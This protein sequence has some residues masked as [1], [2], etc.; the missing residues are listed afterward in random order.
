MGEVKSR[1]SRRR[2][3]QHDE[4]PRNAPRMQVR[5]S[6]FGRIL[7]FVEQFE[8]ETEEALGPWKGSGERRL[9]LHM[10]RSHLA[11]RLVTPSSLV[12]ASGLGYGTGVR[13]VEKMIKQNLIARRPRTRSGKTFSLHP[14]PEMIRLWHEYTRRIKTLL[15]ST[16]GWSERGEGTGDYFFG[17][18]YMCAQVIPPLLVLKERLAIGGRLRLLLHADPTFMAMTTV[19]RQLET[20]FGAEIW[21]RALSIDRLH[22]E[23]LE[24]SARAHSSYDIIACDL[25]W[26]GELAS[27][28]VLLPL[29]DLLYED[30]HDLSD[31]HPEAVSSTSWDEIQYGVPVQTSPELLV[32]RKDLFDEAGLEEPRSVEALLE[33]ACCLHDPI[34]GRA[35]IAWNAARGTPIGHTFLMM[36]ADFGQPVID[37]RKTD[38][39]FCIHELTGNRYRPMFLSDAARSAAEFM[40]EL[41][42]FSP[43]NILNMSWYERAKCYASGGAAMAYCYTLLAS[44][45]ER[46]N[47]SPAYRKT[48]Y[49]PHPHG[50]GC[51]P[52]APLG[53]YALALPSNL[54]EERSAEA[55]RA[56]KVLT[57]PGA[58]KLYLTQ[59]SSTSPRFS[60]GE[61]PD[62][63]SLCPSIPIVDA[64]ARDGVLQ[65]WPRP[66]I[67]E[68]S[69]II[70]VV[71]DEMHA[72]LRGA[73]SAD[74]ALM[75][76]QAAVD[77]L[78]RA[79]GHY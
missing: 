18:S 33:A 32:Y 11:G 8:D 5:Q 34:R 53:G 77:A 20:V 17:A 35:G 76:A 40:R 36:M 46:D 56:M 70:D 23:I 62:V 66:P 30:G 63:W 16:F 51:A 64:M 38:L 60:V 71:G 2:V 78:M 43:P 74:D 57:S 41:L 44:P 55:W 12:S 25:P 15:G 26:F 47:A 54:K 7:D 37:L 31:F 29:S 48:G 75:S 79:H 9:M 50:P 19:K 22:A 68:I 27:K 72:M 59:G 14:T 73:K 39:G 45:F 13:A 61:D 1:E 58:T 3:R 67:P 52:V 10:M 65:C 49:L 24:N 28:G 21:I 6:E 69:E 42:Q 4:M